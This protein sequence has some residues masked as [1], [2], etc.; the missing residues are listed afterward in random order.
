MIIRIRQSS[1]KLG[2][3]S[4]VATAKAIVFSRRS[5]FEILLF[6]I[7]L[8]NR[9]DECATGKA[10]PLCLSTSTSPLF[11]TRL[12]ALCTAGSDCSPPNRASDSRNLPYNIIFSSNDRNTLSDMSGHTVICFLHILVF[13]FLSFTASCSPLGSVELPILSPSAII[14]RS[15]PILRNSSGVIEVFNPDTLAVIPQGDASDG[16]GTVGSPAFIIWVVFCFLVGVPMALGGVR[17]WRFTIGISLGCGAAGCGMYSVPFSVQCVLTHIRLE[18]AWA[19][20]NNAVN[21]Q[22]I[23]DILIV[24]IVLAFFSLGFILGMF[25]FA[26]QAGM[27]VLAITG[28]L[29]FGLRVVVLRSNLLVPIYWVNWLIVGLFGAL[30]AI[31]FVWLDRAI[32]VRLPSNTRCRD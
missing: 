25:E 9:R 22:G 12:W 14:P 8:G 15:A 5:I 2:Q 28:G 3:C 32:V 10:T 24:V 19:A 21:D 31:L 27:L 6:L 1:P 26:R 13:A 18:L 16:A 11:L 23:S 20:I 30:P 4:A 29:G 17:G 7:S